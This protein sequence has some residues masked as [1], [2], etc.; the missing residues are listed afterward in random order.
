MPRKPFGFLDSPE[1]VARLC[2]SLER[3]GLT[4]EEQDNDEE[5]EADP[6]H[7]GC[8]RFTCPWLA[9][10]VELRW[11]FDWWPDGM[12]SELDRIEVVFQGE[13]RGEIH[14]ASLLRDRLPRPLA[15]VVTEQVVAACAPLTGKQARSPRRA[16]N[17]DETEAG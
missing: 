7:P 16:S 13:T 10:G 8:L 15:E 3:I 6:N 17:A 12:N 4:L 9:E 2:R 11:H 1:A 5:R 14:I